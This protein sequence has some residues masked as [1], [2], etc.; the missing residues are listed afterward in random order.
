MNPRWVDDNGIMPFEMTLT[1][2]LPHGQVTNLDEALGSLLSHVG[3]LPDGECDQ[4]SVGYRLAKECFVLG[5]SRTWSV[6]EMVAHLDTTRPTLYRHLNRL[7][8]LGILEEVPPD[9]DKEGARKAYRLRSGN[10][11][12]AWDLA[13]ATGF[14]ATRSLAPGP[15]R[16]EEDA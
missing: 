15:L 16:V 4:G 9:H 12:R 1:T 14:P 13:E 2:A 8:A 11:S 3:Y 5:A 7:K 10:L 6:E